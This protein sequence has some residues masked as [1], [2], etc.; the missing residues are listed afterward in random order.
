MVVGLKNLTDRELEV[1]Q[2]IESGCSYDEISVALRITYQTVKSHLA[3][4][5]EKLGVHSRTQVI[6]RI[7]GS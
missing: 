7:Y 3:H 6:H 2:L 1:I 4:I 5:Y